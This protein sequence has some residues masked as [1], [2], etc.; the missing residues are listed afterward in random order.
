MKSRTLAHKTVISLF[1]KFHVDTT[2]NVD[3]ATFESSVK[4]ADDS[5]AVYA[6][7]CKKPINVRSGEGGRGSRESERY[8]RFQK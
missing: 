7:D 6:V 5:A 8:V 4:I 2:N 1:A 3:C